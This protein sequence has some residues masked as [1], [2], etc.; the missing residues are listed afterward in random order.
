MSFRAESTKPNHCGTTGNLIGATGTAAL[1]GIRQCI[2]ETFD[3]L[4][5]QI[6]SGDVTPYIAPFGMQHSQPSSQAAVVAIVSSLLLN[7]VIN[8]AAIQLPHGMNAGFVAFVTSIVLFIGVS[9]LT[10]RQHAI[11]ADIDQVMDF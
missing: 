3:F 11:D 6:P 2:D 8:V 7:V 5:E 1:T 9:L 4:V 10:Q